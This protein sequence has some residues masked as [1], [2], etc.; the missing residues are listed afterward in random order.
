MFSSE[1]RSRW[2][3]SGGR[4]A[5]IWC[6]H[7]WPLPRRNA[8][9]TRIVSSANSELTIPKPMSR[10]VPAAP[11]RRSGSLPA[12]SS[13]LPGDVV[14]LVQVAQPLVLLDELREVVGVLRHVLREVV[15]LRDERRD[16]QRDQQDRDEQQ[17]DVD[18]RDR[19]AALHV[20]RGRVHERRQRDGQED[21]DQQPADRLPQQEQQVQDQ[22][23][24]DD[25]DHGPHD[26]SDAEHQGG[27]RP[28]GP[29]SYSTKWRGTKPMP[30]R[31]GPVWAE[32]TGPISLTIVGSV[33]KIS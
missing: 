8:V 15:R 32:S 3:C 11:P 5:M 24:A 10:S 25:H 23:H 22:D 2:R 16:D 27:I 9:I 30:S 20:P 4:E 7:L 13:S 19:K 17:A 33:P 1:R 21:R 31:P 18:D 26:R 28:A 6:T 14:V 12:S 29:A